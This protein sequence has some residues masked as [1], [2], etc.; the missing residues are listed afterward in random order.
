MIAAFGKANGVD[1]AGEGKGALSRVAERVLK[2]ID[3]PASF[4][5]KTGHAQNLEGLDS[6][7]SKFAWL[8]PYCWTVHCSAAAARKLESLRPVSNDRLGGDLTSI[9]APGAG[10]ESRDDVSKEK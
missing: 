8:E 3:D 6:G 5:A 1:L 10:I 7:A 2:G 4:A 9:F